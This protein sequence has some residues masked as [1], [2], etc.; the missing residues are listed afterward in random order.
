MYGSLYEV[1]IHEHSF[2]FEPSCD[3]VGVLMIEMTRDDII[4]RAIT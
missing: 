4:D 3:E 2:S 1:V